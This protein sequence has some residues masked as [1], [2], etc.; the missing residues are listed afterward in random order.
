MTRPAARTEFPFVFHTIVLRA[1]TRGINVG[2]VSGTRQGVCVAHETVTMCP[3]SA[4]TKLE[5]KNLS[6]LKP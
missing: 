1:H 4:R 5:K 2:A 3:K 6:L